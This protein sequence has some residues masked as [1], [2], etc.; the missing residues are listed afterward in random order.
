MKL[1]LH[2]LIVIIASTFTATAQESLKPIE[3]TNADFLTKVMDYKSNPTVWNYLGDKPAIIDF[4]ATWC[5]PCRNIAPI[6]EELVKEYNGQI[7]VYKINVD[8][9]QELS[10]TFGIQ[11]LPTLLFVPLEGTPQMSVGALNKEQFKHA[12]DTILLEK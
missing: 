3:L 4:Y 8:N 6:L 1:I 5:G 12:I 10:A 7:V 9:E 2:I 11:S